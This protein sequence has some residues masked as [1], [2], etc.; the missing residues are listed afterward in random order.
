[1]K[2]ILLEPMARL[3]AIGEHVEVKRGYAL[4]FLLPQ[5]KALRA[6]K[7]T[8]AYFEARKEEMRK[9]NDKVKDEARQLAEHIGNV[10]LPI[11]CKA[12]E[13][14][15]LYGSVSVRDVLTALKEQKNVSLTGSHV[16][17]RS[18]IKDLGM[19]PC[20]LM[21][22]PDVWVDITLNV[23]RSMDAATL[24]EKK[25]R[26]STAQKGHKKTA[27]TRDATPVSSSK[28]G[29]QGK[30]RRSASTAPQGRASLHG[31]TDIPQEDKEKDAPT[32]R[33]HG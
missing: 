6:N 25:A 29:E 1:M 28:T 17:L 23:A 13:S 27:K 19:H 2:V 22:H 21:L 31:A 15:H 3:G 26:D 12:S 7:E 5:K 33:D 11:I 24:Q 9:R 32:E 4:N 18:K 10:T 20:R 30:E 16:L 14:G 8:I